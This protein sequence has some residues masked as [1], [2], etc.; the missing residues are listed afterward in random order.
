MDVPSC[1]EAAEGSTGHTHLNYSW[2]VLKTWK[3]HRNSKQINQELPFRSGFY[4]YLISNC[5]QLAQELQQAVG[6]CGTTS[7]HGDFLL[8]PS[9]VREAE[10]HQA[11]Q[12]QPWKTK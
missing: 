5:A 3:K 1:M 9:P 10:L 12:T 2:H 4:Q 6:G 11:H 7:S 8:L